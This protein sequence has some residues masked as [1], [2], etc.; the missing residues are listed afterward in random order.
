MVENKFTTI[1]LSHSTKELLDLCK[2]HPRETYDDVT[3]RLIKS[4]I[5]D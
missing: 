5:H 1:R 4:K 3:Q 2:V